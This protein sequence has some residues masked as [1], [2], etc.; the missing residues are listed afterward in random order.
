MK[1]IWAKREAKYFFGRD[2]TGSISLIGFDKFAFWRKGFYA[3]QRGDFLS[4]VKYITRRLH[5]E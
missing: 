4:A 1:V 3:D 2:W 5:A